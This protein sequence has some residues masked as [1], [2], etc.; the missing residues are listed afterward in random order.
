M[1]RKKI[2]VHYLNQVP[3]EYRNETLENVTTEIFES[4]KDPDYL[5]IDDEIKIQWNPSLF[6]YCFAHG[7]LTEEEL[8]EKCKE[9]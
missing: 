9:N 4:D 1:K 8:I 3:L 2:T 5:I 7:R 6:H